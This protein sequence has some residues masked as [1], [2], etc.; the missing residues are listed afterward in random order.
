M[1]FDLV[2]LYYHWGICTIGATDSLAVLEITAKELLPVVL[3]AAVWR[4]VWIGHHILLHTDNLAVVTVIQNLN[5]KDNLLYHLMRC[6]YFYAA[7]F[8]FKFSASHV[9]RIYNTA[10]D[11]LSPHNL[12]FTSVSPGTS[13]DNHCP[14]VA[15]SLPQTLPR[16]D[17]SRVD[18]TVQNLIAAG[19]PPATASTY[20]A[21][22]QHFL[23]F[24]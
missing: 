23:S 17:L 14:V 12:S 1:Q 15:H 3:A 21:G 19:I 6:I 22:L 4:S 11:A 10:A 24:C 16:M 20:A 8:N 7:H 18:I 5:V 9:V 13:S 2:L